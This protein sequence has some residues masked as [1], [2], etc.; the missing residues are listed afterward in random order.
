MQLFGI[1]DEAAG[2]FTHYFAA[3]TSALALRSFEQAVADEQS[4]ISKWPEDHTLYR[5]ADIDE[6]TGEVNPEMM[7]L[8]KAGNLISFE[9]TDSPEE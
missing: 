6:Q 3:K 4:N 1:K 7:L 5:L 9:P 8:E 2:G